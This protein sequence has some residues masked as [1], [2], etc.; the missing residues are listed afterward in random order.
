MTAAEG[1]AAFRR[2]LLKLSGEA[3]MG[4]REYGQDPGRI[5]AV[6]R[7][8]RDVH[9]LGTEQAIVVGGGN[10]LRGTQRGR[11]AGWTG[12]PPTTRGCSPR[13]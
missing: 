6:A 12:R 4:E 5:A 1:G 13:S 7:A 9:E 8:V 11:A 10:I 2:V 3:L